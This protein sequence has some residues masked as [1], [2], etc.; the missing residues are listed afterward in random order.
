MKEENTYHYAL[1][2]EVLK[3]AVAG[4][5]N[6]LVSYMCKHNL[7]EDDNTLYANLF[8]K[9]SRYKKN[10]ISDANNDDAIL[11]KISAQIKVYRQ[12]VDELVGAKES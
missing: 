6:K 12:Q 4:E 10:I 7:S 2:Q 5:F 1:R 9:I 11:D 8:W 3:E